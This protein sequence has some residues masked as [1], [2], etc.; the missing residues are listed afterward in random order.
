M[1]V[2]FR[3]TSGNA[4]GFGHL[5]R[6]LTLA[7]ALRER[8]IASM[9]ALSGEVRGLDITSD[10]GYMAELSHPIEGKSTVPLI[11][12]FARGAH[13]LVLDDY[14]LTD[15]RGTEIK[16]A[17]GR[18]KVV[19]IDDLAERALTFADAIL[20]PTVGLPIDVY[21]DARHKSVRLALGPRFA[22]L[23]SEF[24][25]LPPRV[26][27]ENVERVLLSLGGADP[28][29]LTPLVARD[30]AHA[31]PNAR[32]DAV[33]GPLFSAPTI[34]AMAQVSRDLPNVHLHAATARV[35]ELMKAADLAV[36]S[37][38]QTVFELAATGLPTVAI[39]VAENQSR[40]L[41]EMHRAKTLLH[42]DREGLVASLLQ[43]AHDHVGRIHM[44][45]HGQSL[46][47]GYGAVRASE[48]IAE[49]SPV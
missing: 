17:V 4:I 36:C 38:G 23:R 19:V 39:S 41:A 6:C 10:A 7:D 14:A 20:N 16:A 28:Q 47:D 25:H 21:G 48:L 9:F 44:A 3:T 26:C 15:V 34:R 11:A 27:R 40:N 49:S 31:L 18:T 45:E 32:I 24:R 1:K 35:A 42:T 33:C 43:I 22:L 29:G 8:G 5:R 12:E 13:V 2:C 37:G 30:I 46:V